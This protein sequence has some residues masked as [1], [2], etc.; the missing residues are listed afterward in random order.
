MKTPA[1]PRPPT[2]TERRVVKTQT[3]LGIVVTYAVARSFWFQTD[4]EAEADIER[5]VQ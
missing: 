3:K 2:Y 1:L 5:R 4:A